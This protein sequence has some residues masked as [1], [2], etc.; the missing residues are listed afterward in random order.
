MNVI[1]ILL[2]VMNGFVGGFGDG[3]LCIVNGN[4]VI[5]FV[6]FDEVSKY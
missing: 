4:V 6:G 1:V 5:K 2:I 3:V